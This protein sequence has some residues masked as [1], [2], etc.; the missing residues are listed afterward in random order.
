MIKNRD[1]VPISVKATVKW[2]VQ[3][4]LKLLRKVKKAIGWRY[5]KVKKF[6]RKM[7]KGISWRLKRIT[8]GPRK[9]IQNHQKLYVFAKSAEAWIKY[10]SVKEERWR[11]MPFKAF[12]KKTD[13]FFFER[14]SKDIDEIPESNGCRYYDPYPVKIGIIADEFLMDSIENAA[15]F[16]FLEPTG[17]ESKLDDL[18]LMLFVSAWRGLQGE[19]I[20]L[21]HE[22]S[23][24]QEEAFN[25]L[26]ACREK[27]IPIVF[28]SKEDPP[29]Y[30]VFLPFAKV[31]DYI[32]TSCKEVIPDYQRD[33]PN[34]KDVRALPFGIN[35]L[36]HNP[37]GIVNQH[38]QDEV[39][40][41][42]SWMRK[43]P[44][45]QVQQSMLLDGVLESGRDVRIVDRNYDRTPE[46][47]R[48]P[49]KYWK[50][51]SPAV[52]HDVLQRLHKLYQWAL[53]INTVTT[54]ETMF[55][56]RGYEL[57][58]GG[59]VQI[60]NYALG[61]EKKLPYVYIA[62]TPKDVADILKNTTD[63]D[64][65][66]RQMDGV[67]AMMTGETCFDRVAE[68]LD[69]AGI[70]AVQKLR[71]VAVVADEDSLRIREMFAWQTYQERT[72]FFADQIE[73]DDL[74]EF[75]MVA[76][77]KNGACYEVFYLEDMINGF[78]YT[79]SDY[80][81]KDA[82]YSAGIL[83]S[84][85][86]HNYV[87]GPAEPCRTVYWT[88]A[89]DGSLLADAKAACADKEGYSIDCLNFDEDDQSCEIDSGSENNRKYRKTVVVRVENNIHHAYARTFASLK[90][91][92]DFMDTQIVFVNQGEDR[93]NELILGYLSR[94]YPNIDW[95]CAFGDES[96]IADR[97]NERIMTESVI[98]LNAGDEQE[99]N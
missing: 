39:I 2:R 50:K 71:K 43:Y 84:G 26:E 40:F 27:K 36:F 7:K 85:V 76:F 28:Y 49:P 6:L 95:I 5:R 12:E 14:V 1:N 18:D 63:E 86:Q 23:K 4:V 42:G 67:R 73:W 62:K 83:R 47:Y 32:F 81:T 60:A 97:V 22:D 64:V 46:S 79:G 58:A 70:P 91:Q 10:F 92:K 96:Q 20:G 45:R 93:E 57:Q 61:V 8:R 30:Q 13:K 54:S 82:Y 19:W 16:V 72:L 37:I 65:F 48:Y 9:F 34:I 99:R 87:S 78:K 88:A 44:E 75:D 55:A 69:M 51:L 35:P 53:N 94:K 11:Y 38:K 66:I 31:C 21:S 98:W 25:I 29:N 52:P 80:I 24:Q 77:W 59:N 17:W 15:D 89:F 56:N 33:C 3:K 68:I 74:S 41:S 90:R